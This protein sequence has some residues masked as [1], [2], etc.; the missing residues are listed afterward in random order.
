MTDGGS[1]RK[2]VK[3]SALFTGGVLG[4]RVLQFAT[5]IIVI[6]LLEVSEYGLL[7]LGTTTVAMLT[8]VSM[9]GLK[10]AVPR[11]MAKYRGQRDRRVADQVAGTALACAGVLSGLFAL[12]LYSQAPLVARMFDKPVMA[13]VFEVMALMLPGAVLTETFAAIFRGMENA[14][15]KVVFKDLV[16]NLS[17]LALL[18]PVALAGLG[19]QEVLW[20]YVC[21]A[22]VT[23]AIS[24]I[25]MARTVRGVLH[26]RLSWV[27]VK[28]LVWFSLPLLGLS[29]MENVIRWAA[30]LS[31]GY[32]QPAAELGRFT[33]PLRLAAFLQMPL[34]GMDFLFLPV[35]SKLAAQGMV[36]EVKQLFRITTKW[37]FLAT[38]P[39]LMYFVVDAEF[40][41]TFVFGAAY[42]ESANVLRILAVGFA[43]NAF[44]G[45][46]ASVLVAFGDTRTQF[47]L[48]MLSAAAAV[49]LCLLLVPRYG[50]LGAAV[51]TGTAT[52]ITNV[53]IGFVLFRKFR[54]HPLTSEYVKPVLLV[55]AG[56]LAA[57][58]FLQ[59]LHTANPLVH[60]SLLL[61]IVALT[62]SSPLLT[63][64]LSYADLDL[65]GS[66]ERRIRGTSGVTE[67]L[68]KWVSNG[69]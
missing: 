38:L 48:S 3:G 31:L 17:R 29:I 47:V 6:R 52:S 30:T 60:L 63:G 32:L 42:H 45:P 39:L 41:V 67:R 37:S 36:L 53:L 8:V 25:H 40:V 44:T 62:L 65:I 4:A 24:V 19:F 7:T 12:L 55:V 20:V 2:V 50:A 26:P 33:A 49:M 69:S 13:S 9:L 34:F 14:R 43:V 58:M 22:W 1:F 21:A 18:V 10:T 57:G 16:P 35:I 27:L 56:A 54:I 59:E 11:F 64:T 23:V 66:V 51:G 28:E 46:N 5:A 61:G 68:R 15:A